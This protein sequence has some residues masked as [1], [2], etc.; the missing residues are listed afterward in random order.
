MTDIF[1]L[2][3]AG[4]RLVAQSNTT[5]NDLD[6]YNFD[7]Q[8]AINSNKGKLTLNHTE[9]QS[10]G[11]LYR[12]KSYPDPLPTCPKDPYKIPDYIRKP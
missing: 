7:R 12:K 3:P 9:Y 1:H 4:L 8:K 10:Q 2:L 5:Y 11:N 6:V